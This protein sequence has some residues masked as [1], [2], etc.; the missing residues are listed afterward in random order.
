M[1]QMILCHEQL[2]LYG[3]TREAVIE[4]IR[5]CKD[6]DVL[7]TYLQ[8]RENEVIDIMMALFD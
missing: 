6:R 3:K 4:T 7:R 8:E 1:T 5:I 2:K